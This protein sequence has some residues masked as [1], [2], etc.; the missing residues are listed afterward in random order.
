M[1]NLSVYEPAMRRALEL[2]LLGP[3]YGVNPQVGAIILD[4]DLKVI[5]EG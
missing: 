2:S 1:R 3:A 5:A 4:K